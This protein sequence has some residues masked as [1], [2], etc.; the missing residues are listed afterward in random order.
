M[1]RLAIY[2]NVQLSFWTDNK[3]E[4]DFTPEDKYFYIYLLTNPQTNICGCYEVSFNQMTRQTGY[5]KE[6]ILRLIERFENVHKV[7]RYNTE[8]KEILLINWYKYNWSKSEKTL[9]GVENVAK[10]IKCD[11]FREYVNYII[12]CIRNDTPIMGHTCPIQASVSDTDTDSDTD[13]VS[14]SITDNKNKDTIKRII[15]YLNE[16]CGTR[17]KTTTG[18][19]IKSINARISEGYTEDDFYTV[20][21]KKCAEW[22]GTEWEKYL[23]PDTLFRPSNFESYVNQKITK[24]KSKKEDI[25]ASRQSQLDYLLNSIKEAEQN[26]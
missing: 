20:I 11:E 18:N 23:R 26:E 5:N 24:Q 12:S 2:R 7:I 14:D 3:V 9:V 13:T 1:V 10:H 17:Y 21:D 19:T 15:D 16:K 25:N 22:I 4:D 8:T 6:T